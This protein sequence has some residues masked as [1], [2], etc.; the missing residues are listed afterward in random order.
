MVHPRALCLH[1]TEA[2]QLPDPGGA[3]TPQGAA[4]APGAD[5]EALDD[6]ESRCVMLSVRASSERLEGDGYV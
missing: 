6:D 2:L 1:P 4:P 3:L 5:P